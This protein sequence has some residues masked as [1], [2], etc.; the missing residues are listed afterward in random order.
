[1][2]LRHLGQDELQIYARNMFAFSLL[3]LYLR[4]LEAFLFLELTGTPVIMLKEMVTY[5]FRKLLIFVHKQ[6]M[7]KIED[8]RHLYNHHFYNSIP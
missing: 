3:I 8:Q 1:M 5:L 6:S 7:I 4:F 2:L